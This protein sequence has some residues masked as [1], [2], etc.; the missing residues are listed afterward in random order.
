MLLIFPAVFLLVG[1]AL[2]CGLGYVNYRTRN[3]LRAIEQARW[4][5]AGSPVGGPVKIQGVAR[6]V[7]DRELL[8]SPIEQQPCVYYRLVIEQFQQNLVSS[9]SPGRRNTNSGSWVRIIE[10]TQAVPMVVAD[11]TGAI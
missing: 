1:L 6:A 3:Y 2:G 9:P 7:D 5:K 8:V 10:D 11:E 4:C